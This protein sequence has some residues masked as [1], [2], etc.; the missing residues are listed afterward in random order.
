[1]V[2]GDLSEKIWNLVWC[3]F[4]TN[5]FEKSWTMKL[6]WIQERKNLF[7]CLPVFI[8][9]LVRSDCIMCSMLSDCNC[10]I[11]FDCLDYLYKLCHILLSVYWVKRILIISGAIITQK[12][13]TRWRWQMTSYKIR[14]HLPSLLPDPRPPSSC[15]I[16]SKPPPP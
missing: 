1:M 12:A 14:G 7:V 10:T 6:S 3:P 11:E 15:G 4:I 8:Y 2:Y 16:F 5:H 9:N 13:I